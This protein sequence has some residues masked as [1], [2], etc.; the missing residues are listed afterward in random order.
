MMK[1]I[2]AALLAALLI[3]SLAACGSSAAKT[4]DPQALADAL[5]AGCQFDGNLTAVSQDQLG[6]MLEQM[7][8]CRAAA[9][10][11]DG[12]T[13]EMIV[14]AQ[15]ED[16]AGTAAMKAALE[17]LLAEQKD[18]AG[19]YQPEELQRLEG[20]ILT[21]AGNCVV[22]CVTSDTDAANAIIKENTK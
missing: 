11:S 1:R 10:M 20:A 4:V 22:L 6:F 3:A 18:E 7:P 14:A 21:V 2:L 5:K 15:C 8:E 16:A 17:T 13:K 19:K 9:Y 12:T